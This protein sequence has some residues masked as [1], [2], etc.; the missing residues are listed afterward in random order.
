MPGKSQE[1]LRERER[2]EERERK[3]VRERRGRGTPS[4]PPRMLLNV[5]VRVGQT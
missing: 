1:E 5:G 4:R 2:E 3:D